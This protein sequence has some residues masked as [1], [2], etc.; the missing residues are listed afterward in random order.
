MAWTERYVRADAAG[1]G[2]GTTTAASGGTGAFTW[3]EM[4]ADTTVGSVRY[5]ILSTGGVFNL[6]STDSFTTAGTATAP[7]SIR[8]GNTAAGDLT[9]A[10]TAG[11]SLTVT[12]FP[13]IRYTSTGRI[14]FPANAVIEFMDIEAAVADIAVT[15]GANNVMRKCKVTS[16][17]AA[18][19]AARA[20]SNGTNYSQIIDCDFAIA[21]SHASSYVVE[22][23]RGNVNGCRISAGSAGG[24]G[25]DL[26]SFGVVEFC[27]I[28]NAATGVN[29]GS[30]MAYV[31]NCSFRNISGNYINNGSEPVHVANCVAWGSGGSSKW[32]NSAGSV[33]A[34]SQFN[35]AVGNMG[36]GDT[37]E[38]EW[39]V[40]GEVALSADPFTS[41]SDLTLNNTAGGGADCRGTG[42]HPYLDIG[43]WQ[44]QAAASGGLLMPN[45][46]GNFA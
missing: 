31:T 39:P 9:G 8:G 19:A 6:T 34:M 28:I 20:I 37:N 17:N 29:V 25:I 12:N 46:R 5:N 1:G 30:I 11:G 33:R 23:S 24:G 27:T 13:Q 4:L 16:S 32:Y 7:R 35:N 42:L 38:G 44:V 15:L 22:H 3:A 45:L 18:S 14:T 26:T 43:A 36:A 41:S 40:T 10:R 21:S 2:D